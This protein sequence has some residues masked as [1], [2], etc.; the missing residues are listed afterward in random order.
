[1]LITNFLCLDVDFF[2]QIEAIAVAHTDLF[3]CVE[4]KDM[5]P[6]IFSSSNK[7]ITK[8]WFQWSWFHIAWHVIAFHQS[9]AGKRKEE[10]LEGNAY[11]K[12]RIQITTY[13]FASQNLTVDPS[14][15]VI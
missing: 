1:M 13:W 14:A 10:M 8:F 3:S 7:L 15:V 2:S 9:K 11:E 4:I 12:E 5:D 6:H